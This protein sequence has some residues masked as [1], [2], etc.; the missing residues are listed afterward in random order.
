MKNGAAYYGIATA[1]YGLILLTLAAIEGVLMRG[2]WRPFDIASYYG[3][4]ASATSSISAI[5]DSVVSS[6]M[7]LFDAGFFSGYSVF[8]TVAFCLASAVL[9][10]EMGR[11]LYGGAAGF[12]A[13]LLFTLNVA[14]AQG[15]MTI[16]EA[17][18][19]TLAL[20][21]AY[22]L[23]FKDG[24]Y[25]VPGL[26]AGIA[27][28]FKPLAVLLLPAS[29]FFIYKRG[30]SRDLLV[31]AGAALLPLI[32]IAM[33]ALM[34]FGSNTL[35]MAAD[36]GFEAV[37]LLMEEDYRSPDALMAVANIVLSACLLASLL[38]LAL[39][40]FSR[41][42]GLSEKYFLAA[43]LCFVA[44]VVLKQYLHYWFFA[45][46]FLALLCVGAFGRRPSSV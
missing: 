15:H 3:L 20:L 46:P 33:A 2:L 26:C 34:V 13:G 27:A 4:A 6:P 30:G 18:A 23:L 42:H 21:S 11:R 19:L 29:L 9:V 17:M 22:A 5:L 8:I 32:L 28:C 41:E 25:V 1:A 45:L 44:T 38:P 35:T 40:G 10:L 14:G 43:G 37:G 39:L 7:L 31:F 36:S 16:V 24:R 12:L